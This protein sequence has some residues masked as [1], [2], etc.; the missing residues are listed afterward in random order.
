MNLA[1]L[2]EHSARRRGER[3][4]L[5]FEGERFTNLQF[6]DWARR[7]QRGFSNLGLMR[8][9]IAV[10]YMA[11]HP[12]TYP[13]FQ[14]IFRTGALAIPVMFMI[15]APEL[16]Y[17]LSDSGAQGVVTDQANVAKVREA[18]QGLDHIR[19]IVVQGGDE[20][21]EASPPEYRLETFLSN[22]PQK[23]L[24]QINEDD[25]A[26]MLYT[27]GTT[28]KPKG[29]MLTHANLFASAEAANEAAEL[30]QWEG[31]YIGMRVVL[32]ASATE[33]DAGRLCRIGHWLDTKSSGNM[34]TR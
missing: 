6:L 17:V 19:W 14:G 15:A 16:R 20:H 5:D 26:L 31:S 8:G 9:E 25:V 27:A 24:P 2:A 21:P 4:V 33:D 1:E 28:G 12:L 23:S 34:F 13:V 30:D 10:L 32:A 18:A 7:L 22:E 3:M 29:V 11:N